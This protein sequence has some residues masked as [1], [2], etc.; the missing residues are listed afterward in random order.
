V[1]ELSE[2]LTG[3][4]VGSDK[5]LA[6]G[7]RITGVSRFS[8][9]ADDNV[10]AV[11]G[12]DD[13]EQKFLVCTGGG[14]G[15]MEA[16]NKGASKAGKTIGMGIS[17]PFEPGLNA[18]VTDSLAFEYH[19]FFTRK[20]WMVYHCQVLI[21][22]PGGVGTMDEIF[23]V[24]TLKQTRKIQSDLPV[25]LLGKEY[26]QTIVN[27]QALVNYGVIGQKDI[28]DLFFTDDVDE[29]FSFIISKLQTNPIF[30]QPTHKHDVEI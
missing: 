2:K 12:D 3:W 8:N 25:I 27:W 1:E 4:A 16:A 9:S 17:L 5:K 28:D 18:Y 24:L 22:A 29:A 15:F 21:V 6:L 26:W 19:Y 10:H 30:A 7:R 11:Q 14:P 13:V 23:E 20:F